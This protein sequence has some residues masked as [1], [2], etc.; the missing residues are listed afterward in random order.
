[1]SGVAAKLADEFFSRLALPT[2]PPA[3]ESTSSY[4]LWGGFALWAAIIWLLF[5]SK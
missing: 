1:L 5:L 3:E 4:W 2:P